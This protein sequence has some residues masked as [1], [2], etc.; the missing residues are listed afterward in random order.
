MKRLRHIC[1]I[2]L[3]T[4]LLLTA[5]SGCGQVDKGLLNE[6]N[7]ALDGLASL[8]SGGWRRETYLSTPEVDETLS[9]SA[10]TW[11]RPS[12]AGA[13]W[14]MG[15]LTYHEDGTVQMENGIAQKAGVRYQRHSFGEEE[16][17]WTA[18]ADGASYGQSEIGFPDLDLLDDAKHYEFFRKEQDGSLTFAYSQA[19][20]DAYHA[21]LVARAEE[22]TEIPAELDG[23]PI[24]EEVRA[25]MEQSRA[26]N[27]AMA[28]Q[29]K[30]TELSG[31]IVLDEAGNL[32]RHQTQI[33]GEAPELDMD[34]DGNW[35][36]S[37]MRSGSMRMA[38][39]ILDRSD[40]AVE[41]KLTVLFA[42][43]P[44]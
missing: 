2:F 33:T 42:D 19:G 10:E 7:S 35:V 34:E 26:V 28:E 39:E 23:Q 21:L 44:S 24:S 9:Q 6:A 11:F 8:E 40:A 14:Y 17:A 30:I 29:S 3:A 41:Q 36:A 37:S 27:I 20:L 1:C 25:S 13:D 16:A 12:G 4:T 22:Q 18:A 43:L 32:L 38:I 31:A 15:S 5:L